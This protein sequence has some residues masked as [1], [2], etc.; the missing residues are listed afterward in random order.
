MKDPKYGTPSRYTSSL[1]IPGLFFSRKKHTL[2]WYNR[3]L[4]HKKGEEYET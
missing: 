1:G 3:Q 4:F 2:L